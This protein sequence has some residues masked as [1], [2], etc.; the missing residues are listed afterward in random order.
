MDSK[1]QELQAENSRLKHD[2]GQLKRDKVRLGDENSQL[3]AMVAEQKEQIQGLVTLGENLKAQMAKLQ[4]RLKTNSGNS[5]KPPSSDGPETPPRPKHK[6]SRR[7][8]GGQ[9]GHKAAT[10]EMASAEEVDQFVPVKPDACAHCGVALAGEDPEPLRHQVIDIPDPR[11]IITEYLLHR[12]RC[13]SCGRWTRAELPDGVGWSWFGPRLHALAGLWVGRFKQTKRDVQAQ[14]RLLFGLRLSTGAIS[15]MERRMSAALK[16]PVEQARSHIRSAAVSHD[17]ETGW[18]QD[19]DRAWLWLA[20]TNSVAVF[21]IARRRSSE[22][23]KYI[24]G[25]AYDGVAVVDRWSAYTW[26]KRRQLCWAHLLRDFTAMAERYSSPWHGG[27]LAK[28]AR[29]VL[30]T[31]AAWHEDEI[32]RA[33]ML[34]RMAPL[35]EQIHTYLSWTAA[36]APGPTARAK[37]RE[38]L[39][40]ENHLW[41]FLAVPAVPPTNNLAERLLRYAVIWRK[42]SYGTD[43]DTGS[44]FVERLL[45][46]VTTLRLQDRDVFGYLCDAITA[47]QQGKPAPSIL[48]GSAE[49]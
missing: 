20:A 11:V 29:E 40:V 19:K 41:T 9:P 23:A 47:Y 15:A 18:W 6:R 44:R 45:T 34:E 31:W 5:S 43:S 13:P 49:G 2:N 14:F 27:R 10:R 17:D 25:K 38:I 26:I 1:V 35:Q 37:A 7:K 36:N 24:L 4:A 42:I 39:K 30:A 46:V 48:P 22:V 21:T 16:E 28:T 12:L 8:R 3:Q 33:T 32:D